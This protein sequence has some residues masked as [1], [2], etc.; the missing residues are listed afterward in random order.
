MFKVA[1]ANIVKNSHIESNPTALN[2]ELLCC[3][4]TQN[5]IDN[6]KI[7]YKM[8]AKMKEI[9]EIWV[10]SERIGKGMFW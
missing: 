4:T 9:L 5:D 7:M 6:Q 3:A 1:G 8:A 2:L 10:C